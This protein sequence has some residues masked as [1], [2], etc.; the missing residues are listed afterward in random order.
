MRIIIAG[1]G[2]V[3][4]SLAHQLTDEG[5]ELILI[6]KL[7]HVIEE[8]TELY[9]AMGV[10]GNCATQDILMQAQVKDFDLLIAATGADEVN[11]LC[12]MVAHKLNPHIHTI[13]RIRN[14]EYSDQMHQMREMF[15]LSLVVNPERMAAK[16]IERLLKYP[17]FLK[18]DTFAK[19]RVEI[20]EL[21]LEEN[22]PLHNQSL[23]KLESIVRCKVLVCV[24]LR[25]GKAIA[26]SG[27]FVLKSGDRIF[28]TAPINSLTVLLKS[29]G[30]VT[31]KNKRVFICGGG[32]ISFYLASMLNRDGFSVQLIERDY[33]NC[34]RFADAIPGISVINGDAGNQKLLESEGVAD[35]DAIVTLTGV[36]ELN[37][38][39]SLYGLGK[40]VPQVITK[41][42]HFKDSDVI[43][44]LPL[45]SI[46]SPDE[47]CC[48]VIVRYVRAMENQSGAAV[49][50]HFIADRHAEA[51]EF[52]VDDSTLF[53][54]TPL[55][56]IRTKDNMLIACITHRGKTELPNGNSVFS[57]GDTVLIVSTSDE[58]IYQLNDIFE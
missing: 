49:A 1:V 44:S 25:N 36:D 12:C 31:R 21:K 14:P 53:C 41:I 5:H 28:V 23:S 18:R 45:G 56:D 54:G 37:I 6:D 42:S 51:I 39:L 40:G 26:P 34:V 30:I 48:N 13:A 2:K 20:V 7:E 43:N 8:N 15:N 27:D 58:T 50:V 35:C 10:C 4:S 32:R 19:G 24:V 29:L 3:G 11:L 46:I 38:I 33:D 17:G 16:E 52:R 57:V 55:K 22:S 47:L 9:D